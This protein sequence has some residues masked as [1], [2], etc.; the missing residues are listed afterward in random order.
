MTN[1]IEQEED[2]PGQGAEIQGVSY[3]HLISLFETNHSLAM[4]TA[5]FGDECSPS[6]IPV[7][8][9]ESNG[10]TAAKMPE[11]SG[12]NA[13]RMDLLRR[14]EL[15]NETIQATKVLRSLDCLIIE[16]SSA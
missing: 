14:I 12:M 9:R 8:S 6:K 16:L 15:D 11:S 7:R 4:R 3:S 13:A 10:M 2:S 5:G 1:W